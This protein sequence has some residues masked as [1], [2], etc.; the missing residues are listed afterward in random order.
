MAASSRKPSLTSHKPLAFLYHTETRLWAPGSRDGTGQAAVHKD[1]LGSAPCPMS[2]F[3]LVLVWGECVVTALTEVL[4]NMI[5]KLLTQR[6]TKGRWLSK[7]LSVKLSL[8]FPPG[9]M[10]TLHLTDKRR[11]GTA[12]SAVHTASAITPQSVRPPDGEPCPHPP[13]NRWGNSTRPPRWV[14]SSPPAPQRSSQ[15]S[16][17]S[18]QAGRRP[19]QRG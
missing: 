11:H 5:L 18:P 1:Q 13:N 9:Q 16:R 12:P 3:T 14:C 7:L 6:T 15:G 19:D 10:S 8:E 17:E 2:L 4:T